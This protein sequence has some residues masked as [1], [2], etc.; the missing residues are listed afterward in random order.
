MIFTNKCLCFPDEF[1]D[2]PQE[3]ASRSGSESPGR[4]SKSKERRYACLNS[5]C[6][7]TFKYERDL[8][9]HMKYRC[10]KPKRYKCGHCDYQAH[11]QWTIERHSA[12]IHKTLDVSIVELFSINP[13]KPKYLCPNSN[14]NR[15]YRRKE[16]CSRHV[17]FECGK[18]PGLKC[19]YCDF[20]NWFE[21]RVKY[22]HKEKHP[23]KELRIVTLL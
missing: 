17:N 23:D 14:C 13:K 21:G 9:Y 11:K 19:F 2:N 8:K 7:L 6:N 20:K 5:D 3:V 22:H 18:P 12:S 16:D 15:A 1:E 10:N 4:V